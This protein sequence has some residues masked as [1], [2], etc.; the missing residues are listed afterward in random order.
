MNLE[1]KKQLSRFIIDSKNCAKEEERKRKK[2]QDSTPKKEASQ[3]LFNN[4]S[5][6]SH[7]YLLNAVYKLYTFGI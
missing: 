6:H 3:N 1:Q 2:W 5:Q 4:V 7:H